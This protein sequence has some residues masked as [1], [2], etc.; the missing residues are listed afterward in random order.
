MFLLAYALG[1]RISLDDVRRLPEWAEAAL[2]LEE[3][4]AERAER[5]G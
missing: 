2:K 5:T 3:T 4:I 1:A